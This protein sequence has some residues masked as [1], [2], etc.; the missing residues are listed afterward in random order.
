MKVLKILREEERC[1][2]TAPSERRVVELRNPY[3]WRRKMPPL[4]VHVKA[5]VRLNSDSP[6][7]DPDA[8]ITPKVGV[9]V[10]PITG[11]SYPYMPKRRV[12]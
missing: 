6:I 2:P 5:N 12:R 7:R 8:P 4:M 10:S 11:R 1:R 3:G 9:Y